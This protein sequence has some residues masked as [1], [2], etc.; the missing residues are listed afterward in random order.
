M[1][2]QRVD[3][4]DDRVGAAGDT[5]PEDVSIRF[6]HEDEEPHPVRAKVL[7]E[8]ELLEVHRLAVLEVRRLLL[9]DVEGSG[10]VLEAEGRAC[11]HIGE[12]RFG[13]SA[14]SGRTREDRLRSVADDRDSSRVRAKHAQD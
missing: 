8:V 3:G 2:A 4:L 11:G 9:I 14:N 12:Q 10:E 1:D 6:T 7:G 13:M 5:L